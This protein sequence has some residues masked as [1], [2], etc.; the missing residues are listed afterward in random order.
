MQKLSEYKY[1]VLFSTILLVAIIYLTANIGMRA[2]LTEDKRYSLTNATKQLLTNVDSVIEIDVF[3]T[4]NLPADYKKLSVATK[5]LLEE[6]SSLSGNLVRVKFEKP[7]EDIS[8]DTAKAI[9]YDSLARLGVVFERTEVTNTDES[10]SQLIIPSALVKYGNRKPIA[11][12]LRSSR[13]VFKQY[14]VVNDVEPLEDKEA[15]RNAAEALLEYKFA[16]AI[17]KLTREYIPTIA[18]LVGNGEPIDMKI[19]D[20]GE[21]LRNDYRLAVFDLKQGYPD[22]TIID[23]LVIVKPTSVFTEEDK[24]KL[25]QYVMNGGKIIWFID[26]LHAELDSLMRSQAEYTAYDRGLDI[27]DLLFK[28][29]VRINGDLLQDLNC[30]KIPIVVGRNPDGSP[31][32]QRV[33]WPYY[34]FLSSKTDNPISKN[35]DRVLPI[36]PSS[37]DTVKAPGIQKTILLA[38]DTNSRSISSPALVSLNSVKS[39]EDLFTFNRSYVPVAVLL[40]GKFQSLFANRVGV[41]L[42]D[43]VERTTGKPFQRAALKEGKQIV[44]SDADIVTNALSNT[45]GPLPMGELPFEGYRFANREFFLNCIDYLV[46]NNG[47]FESRNKTI[48]LRLLDKEKIASQKTTWQFINI[49]TPLLALA[50][51]GGII[52]WRRKKKYG[53]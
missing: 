41:D 16:N 6:F 29:G 2:D 38:S 17:D 27:D 12:D 50:I 40:E 18:Y 7:G 51:A 37:I 28:Y 47:L 52:Q 34:P 22:P 30:S 42:M 5:E 33:P 39:E 8:N 23:A 24:L 35:L 21:S 49:V 15:T 14:N 36:F 3:L 32:M 26:K 13:R 9:L 46:S 43:S 44:V 10:T 25:D 53:L 31:N 19:N 20:L 11:I 48:V 1:G 4:G 45:T